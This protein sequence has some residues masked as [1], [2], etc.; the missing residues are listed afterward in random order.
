MAVT[1]TSD[2][3]FTRVAGTFYRAVDPAHRS[4]ALAGSRAAGRYSPPGSP[5]LYLSS[6]LQGV[7]AAMI[8]HRDERV[9][10]LEIV[11]V[12]VEA[13]KIVDLRDQAALQTAGVDLSDAVAPWQQIVAD[14]GEPSSWDVRRR[15]ERLGAAGLIDP[16]RRQPVLWHLTL[17]RWNDDD[18]G[19]TAALRGSDQGR[20][21]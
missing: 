16:S 4:Q 1:D 10:E 14:G 11:E 18:G 15:L 20:G 13:E 19:P 8:A 3:L 2:E 5:T 12:H 21:R 17:F 9:A 6:S 7:Q